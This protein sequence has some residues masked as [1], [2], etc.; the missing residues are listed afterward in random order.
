M[1]LNDI[2]LKKAQS[3]MLLLLKKF[4]FFCEEN[5]ISYFLHA[6]TLL[7]AVRHNGFIPWDDDVDVGMLREDYDKFCRLF[8]KEQ[9]DLVLQNYDTD[10]GF[11]FPFSKLILKNTVW[12]E[13]FAKNT[14]R[15]F[16][17]IYL[18]IFVFDKI[19]NDDKLQRRIYK[20]NKR[21]R[22]IMH[23]KQR[24]TP[25]FKSKFKSYIYKVLCLF[26][27]SVSVKSIQNKQTNLCLKYKNLR[28]NYLVT[29][30]GG[31]FYENLNPDTFY[32]DL[33]KHKFEDSEFFIP[34][35]YDLL[36]TKAYGDYMTPPVNPTYKHQII[37]YNFG[38]YIS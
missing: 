15:N 34:R 31:D 10:D 36:L 19:P 23:A 29:N 33:V 22:A 6:G 16:Q 4:A 12:I 11:G 32:K 1:V 20:K 17:G 26:T 30:L 18:D 24:Y 28:E 35:E 5:N 2:E 38:P 9:D 3:I 27:Y 37:E 21:L 8:N 25:I 14:N 13:S 7:G